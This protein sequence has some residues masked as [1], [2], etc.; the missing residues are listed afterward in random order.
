MIRDEDGLLTGYV[1][2]DIAGRDPQSYVAAAGAVLRDKLQLPPG[3]SISWSGQYEAI[4]RVARRLR[5]ILP[6]TLLLVFL[7]LFMSTRSMV[8]TMIVMLAVPF[9]AVGA[10]WFLYLIGYNMSVA[11][12]VGLIALLGV[13][14]ETGVFMLLYLDL[15]YEDAKRRGAMRSLSDLH[16]AIVQGAAKRLRPKFMTFATMCIGLFPIMWSTGAGAGVMKHIAAPMIGGIFTSFV[17]ELLVYPAI[18]QLWRWHA[19]VKHAA[20]QAPTVSLEGGLLPQAS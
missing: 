6:L 11:V 19:A 8:K 14:A 5:L 4:E 12:W 1:F 16:E 18:Y 9:S 17:L 7:L 2:I 10:I 13:D 3:Y 20:A 15:A